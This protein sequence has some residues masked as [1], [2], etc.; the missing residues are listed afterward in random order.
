LTYIT[1]TYDS[2]VF[3]LITMQCIK[4]KIKI[5]NDNIKCR[6]YIHYTMPRISG[7]SASIC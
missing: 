5:A 7:P 6:K 3:V 1:V 4:K 2:V